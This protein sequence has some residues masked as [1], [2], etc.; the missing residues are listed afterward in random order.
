MSVPVWLLL[1]VAAV[2]FWLM[3]NIHS[4]GPAN[5]LSRTSTR[6]AAAA[7]HTTV[8]TN[9]AFN[10]PD[11]QAL[12]PGRMNPLYDWY[13][14]DMTRGQA[15]V[16][17]APLGDGAFVVRDS[18]ATPGW[19]MLWIKTKQI[20]QTD[21]GKYTLLPTDGEQQPAFI[22]LHEVVNFCTSPQAGTHSS[23]DG[24]EAVCV[25]ERE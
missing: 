16:H 13:H 18:Q 25:W 15:E 11:I 24:L 12:I 10:D 20:R 1:I 2:G 7:A 23:S 5:P 8:Q 22:T 3:V 4:L 21:D 9:V 14:P 17:F 19:H 6:A